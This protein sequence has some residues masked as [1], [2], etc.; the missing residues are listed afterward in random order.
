[1]SFIAK[2]EARIAE[3][4]AAIPSA[5]TTE[6]RAL[7]KERADLEEKLRRVKP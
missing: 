5:K 6:R 4:N 1:M 3:I 2:L 7:Q